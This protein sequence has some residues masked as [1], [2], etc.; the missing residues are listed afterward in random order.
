M[1]ADMAEVKAGTQATLATLGDL[2]THF[3]AV[4][5]RM[6][7]TADRMDAAVTRLNTPALRI[8][9]AAE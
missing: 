7:K 2:R 8:V 5:A 9:P 4:A 6:D 1:R 3:D